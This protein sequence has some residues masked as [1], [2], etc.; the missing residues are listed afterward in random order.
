MISYVKGNVKFVDAQQLFV[1]LRSGEIGFSVGVSQPS[2]FQKDQDVELHTYLHWNQEQGPSLYGFQ[3]IEER[4]LFVLIIGCSGIGPK[5]AL[6]MLSQISIGEFICAVQTHDVKRLSQ[7]KGIGAKKAEQVVLQ[8]R[9]K[10][11]TFAASQ[12]VES[13]GVAKHLTQVSEVL[14]S[15]NYSRVEIQQTLSYLRDKTE[16]SEPAFDQV[17]RQALSFL[18]KKV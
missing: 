18:S 9:D 3:T 5:M 12:K 7:L 10:V 1:V 2:N 6:S 16:S 8:L 15:L 11:D 14:Q 4:C 13:V 17:M